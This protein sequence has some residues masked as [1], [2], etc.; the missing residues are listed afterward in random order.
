MPGILAVVRSYDELADALATQR[1]RS[2]LS[3]ELVARRAGFGADVLRRLEEKTQ[4]P[5]SS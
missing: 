4:F 1:R 3:L 2:G 5:A